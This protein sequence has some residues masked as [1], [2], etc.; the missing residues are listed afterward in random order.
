[1]P[2]TQRYFT[3]RFRRRRSPQ[4]RRGEGSQNMKNV[5]LLT[6]L[7]YVNLNTG[8]ATPPASQ[9]TGANTSPPP[10]VSSPFPLQLEAR[11][12]FAPTAF[13]SAGRTYLCYELYLTNFSDRAM[14]LS[15]IEVL[16]AER[17]DSKSVVTFEDDR[18]DTVLKRF[19]AGA[20]G[21]SGARD[22][23]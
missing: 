3:S 1:M 12:P 14:T 23:G 6:A 4:Q 7:L 22:L 17:A 9:D 11:V 15:R 5:F 13:P 16:D 8:L 10:T 2:G 20:P 21:K 18:L 19:P